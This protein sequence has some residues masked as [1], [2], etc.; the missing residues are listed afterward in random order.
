MVRK[1][2]GLYNVYGCLP[3]IEVLFP[4]SVPRI[5]S[6]GLQGFNEALDLTVYNSSLNVSTSVVAIPISIG[7]FHPVQIRV[8]L[9]AKK[10]AES[11]FVAKEAR[12][13][14]AKLV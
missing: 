7:D 11:T 4:R 3:R 6:N 1:R 14:S 5:C 9:Y 8:G 10:D 12:N 2:D 13:A